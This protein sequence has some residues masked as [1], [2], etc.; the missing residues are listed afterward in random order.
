MAAEK[1]ENKASKTN[2]KKKEQVVVKVKAP[3]KSTHDEAAKKKELVVVKEKAPAKGTHDKAAKKEELVVVKVKVPAEDK[4]DKAAKKKS[5]FAKKIEQAKSTAATIGEKVSTAAKDVNKKS[6]KL[7]AG[8]M[9]GLHEMK[10][11]LHQAALNIAE[12]TK[13]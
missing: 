12:K 2:D 10:K 4:Q 9:V 1:T 13:E 3:A 11:G 5:A 6:E 7:E 8:I